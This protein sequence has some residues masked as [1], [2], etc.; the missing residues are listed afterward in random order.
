MRARE[1][2]TTILAS[3]RYG[4]WVRRQRR[5]RRRRRNIRRAARGLLALLV[6]AVAAYLYLLLG[7]RD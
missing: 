6:L 3:G 7:G 1:V 2:Q 4:E 5:R